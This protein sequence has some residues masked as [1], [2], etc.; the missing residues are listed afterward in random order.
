METNYIIDL[1]GNDQQ[2][3]YADIM[4]ILMGD[5]SLSS[6]YVNTSLYC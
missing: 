2:P 4:G 1:P 3:I 5:H 6:M